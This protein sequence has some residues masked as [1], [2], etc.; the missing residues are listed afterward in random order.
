MQ[1]SLCKVK[2][3]LHCYRK[4]KLVAVELQNTAASASFYTNN[5]YKK[6]TRL[7][8]ELVIGNTQL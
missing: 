8:I 5:L 7:V 3:M 6:E 4:D 2:D 1:P